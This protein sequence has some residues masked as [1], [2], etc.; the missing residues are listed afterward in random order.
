MGRLKP[1]KSPW[2]R[3]DRKSGP[4]CGRESRYGRAVNRRSGQ[5]AGEMRRGR[6]ENAYEWRSLAPVELCLARN[7]LYLA[8]V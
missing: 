7:D 4:A 8:R 6:G 5:E 1:K 2:A 3:I